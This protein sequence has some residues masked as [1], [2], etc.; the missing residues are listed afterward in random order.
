[1]T[2]LDERSPGKEK[3][4]SRELSELKVLSPAR[5]YFIVF[6]V[7]TTGAFA[8]SFFDYTFS[9]NVVP[10]EEEFGWSRAAING[11]QGVGL[12]M[13]GATAPMMGYLTDRY[14]PQRCI[15]ICAVIMIGAFMMQATTETLY[16]WYSAYIVAAAGLAGSSFIAV[17]KTV[18]LQ[19]QDS[20]QRARVMGVGFM[21]FNVVGLAMAQCGAFFISQDYT[22]RT[23]TYLHAIAMAVMLLLALA[24][25]RD[26]PKYTA[27][28][29]TKQISDEPMQQLHPLGSC[30][31]EQLLGGG[32]GRDG[33]HVVDSSHPT[34]QSAGTGAGTG[35]VSGDGPAVL[36]LTTE[37]D[38]DVTA[39]ATA[40][41]TTVT[42]ATIGTP[43]R[44]QIRSDSAVPVLESSLDTSDIA[45]AEEGEEEED[46]TPGLTYRQAIRTSQFWMMYAATGCG[47]VSLFSMFNQIVPHLMAEGFEEEIASQAI[48]VLMAASI[49]GKVSWG[50]IA[51]RIGAPKALAIN[52]TLHVGV[53][54]GLVLVGGGDSVWVI[55]ALY[56]LCSGGLGVLWSASQMQVFGLRAA[57]IIS[58]TIQSV[59]VPVGA[60][61][62]AM[63]GYCYDMT[64][65]YT[66]SFIVNT[67]IF[68]IGAALMYLVKQPDWEA[69]AASQ[70]KK[71]LSKCGEFEAVTA[72]MLSQ[73]CA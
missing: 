52:M 29:S 18:G 49:A 38:D 8:I 62:P 24:F 26:P 13:S 3:R 69:V 17:A 14:G 2:S 46:T 33:S 15:P 9:L 28:K 5:K 7:A 58:G 25:V 27:G 39:T 19:F 73:E 20:G 37:T 53:G 66:I 51:S 44:S 32:G 4:R 23:L 40:T 1:M 36:A 34:H 50:Q 6:I 65:S 48:S 70:E 16:Q 12:A 43:T 41:V 59:A 64:G 56:G 57:G 21:M 45:D 60:V 10:V 63:A 68:G 30:D 42:A 22:W 67:C 47:F 71:R 55:I 72:E 54:T 35:V 11:G 31:E 61:A